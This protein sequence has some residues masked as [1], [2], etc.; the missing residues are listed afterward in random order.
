MFLLWL[1]DY[2]ARHVYRRGYLTRVQTIHF[3][4][5]VLLDDNKRMFFASNYDGSLDSYMDDFINKVAWGI[6]L[7]FSNG[8]GFPRTMLAALR[9]RQV[10]AEI[11]SLPAPAPAADRRLVQGVSRTFGR[12]PEPEHAHPP[13]HRAADNDR[14]RGERMVEPSLTKTTAGAVP[15][16][17]GFD[18]GDDVQG[19]VW[20]GHGRLDR[21]RVPPAGDRRAGG[22]AILAADRAGHHGRRQ[23]NR[24]PRQRCRSRLPARVSRRWASRQARSRSSPTSS[25]TAWRRRRTARAGSGD[26]GANAPTRLGMGWHRSRACRILS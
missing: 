2:A 11:Q 1:L 18:F 12:R 17:L 14:E 19:I 10:R 13:G 15:P 6:N 16:V 9:R 23:P 21:C 4:R 22:R 3:A 8:V 24:G 26:V 5:W 25:S 20:S 7:V